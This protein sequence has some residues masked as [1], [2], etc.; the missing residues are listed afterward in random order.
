MS[1]GHKHG[2]HWQDES[3][4]E[5]A[6]PPVPRDCMLLSSLSRLRTTFSMVGEPVL[7]MHIWDMMSNHKMRITTLG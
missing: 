1:V 7:Q 2:S 3:G 5:L 4:P 6:E